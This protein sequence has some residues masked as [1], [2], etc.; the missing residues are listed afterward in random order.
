VKKQIKKESKE[1]YFPIGFFF[2]ALI[3][4]LTV[5]ILPGIIIGAIIGGLIGAVNTTKLSK[6]KK[7]IINY[8]L[9]VLIL[10]VTFLVAVMITD[11]ADNTYDSSDLTTP[12]NMISYYTASPKHFMD[13]TYPNNWVKDDSQN[14]DLL[15]QLISSDYASSITF[16]E[17][18]SI[19]DSHSEYYQSTT[20]KSIR[21]QFEE[22]SEIEIIDVS[23][24]EID[25]VS[26]FVL[27]HYETAYFEGE[28]IKFEILSYAFMTNYQTL[29]QINYVAEPESYQKHLAEAKS[30][31]KTTKFNSEVII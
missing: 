29:I 8:S 16:K 23:T 15:F 11:N 25:G 22:V 6:T 18:P 24:E 14:Q 13:I 7:N 1:R 2:V 20:E 27:H 3:L 12:D 21:E 4:I 26:T 5:G 9:M 31:I 19:W 30:I 10:I 28:Y 17:Y